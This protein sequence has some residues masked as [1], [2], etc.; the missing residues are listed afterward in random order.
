[1]VDT[2]STKERKEHEDSDGRRWINVS[3][4]VEWQL[5]GDEIVS[6]ITTVTSENPFYSAAEVLRECLARVEAMA[7]QEDEDEWFRSSS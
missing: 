6:E 3:V 4:E 7:D 2:Q 5:G 1:M